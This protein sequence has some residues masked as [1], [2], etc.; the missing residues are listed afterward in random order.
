MT[1]FA[2]VIAEHLPSTCQLVLTSSVFTS[3]K[4]FDI[5]HCHFYLANTARF[6]LTLQAMSIGDF[7][8]QN[9]NILIAAG[10]TLGAIVIGFLVIRMRT[11]VAEDGTVSGGGITRY[12]TMAVIAILVGAGAYFIYDAVTGDPTVST[13]LLS[14]PIGMG[15][16]G[17]LNTNTSTD[18]Q[19]WGIQYWMYVDNWGYKYGQAK[20]VFTRVNTAAG[21]GKGFCPN[22]QLHP[23]DNTLQIQVSLPTPSGPTPAAQGGDAQSDVFTCEVPNIPFQTWFA[24]SISCSGRNLDVYINGKLLKS[25]LIAGVPVAANGD[26][27]YQQNGGFSGKLTGLVTVTRALTPS[28]A[29]SFYAAGTSAASSQVSATQES[30]QVKFGIV[31]PSGK[32]IRK[33]VL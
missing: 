22:V 32:E 4:W 3:L 2:T 15:E 26:I 1:S 7:F 14:T 19:N 21:S 18:T 24:V 5:L 10:A 25:C 12:I 11:T 8:T 13:T 20:N 17:T 27:Q 16:S 28:D 9:K 6:Y 23:T 30:Y 31:D 29:E 33:F